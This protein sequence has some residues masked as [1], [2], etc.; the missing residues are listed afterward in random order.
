MF[1]MDIEMTG[2]NSVAHV[3]QKSRGADLSH[4]AL[5]IYF[6]EDLSVG[7]WD[8]KSG[9]Q[10]MRNTQVVCLFYVYFSIIS[11]AEHESYSPRQLW[12]SF[13]SFLSYALFNFQLLVQVEVGFYRQLPSTWHKS[14]S[15]TI[16]A[17]NEIDNIGKS[18]YHHIIRDNND[19]QA[20][21]KKSAQ[22]SV[23]MAHSN[24]WKQNL[25]E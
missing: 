15:R 10:R 7:L 3:M 23:I 13:F 14:Q 5:E 1:C 12:L 8:I 24:F 18:V 4:Y 16:V 17:L 20:V 21:W 25:N 19:T 9:S 22:S 11:V 6:F 2:W